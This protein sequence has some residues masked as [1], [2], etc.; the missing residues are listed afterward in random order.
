MTHDECAADFVLRRLTRKRYPGACSLEFQNLM[1]I[2]L[3]CLLRWN[4]EYQ[5]SDG[6]GIAGDLIAWNQANEEQGRGSLHAHWQLFTEQLSSRARADLFHEDRNIRD[7]ARK[8]LAD[9]IDN[10][11]CASYGAD[12]EITHAC[13]S[14]KNQSLP[15]HYHDDLA[16]KAAAP[17]AGYIS[18]HIQTFR[19]ARHKIICHQVQGDL[20]ICNKC[21]GFVRCSDIPEDFYKHHSAKRR[22]SGSPHLLL[23]ERYFPDIIPFL[24]SKENTT[25]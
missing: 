12:V 1:D 11:I 7:R 6:M 18:R 5:H 13:N 23:Y 24:Y 22:V 9:Y 14:V 16:K 8:E 17:D 10:M 21:G 2:V 19:N 3:K 20:I 4:T 15:D 25:N